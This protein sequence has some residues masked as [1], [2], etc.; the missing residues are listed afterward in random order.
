MP[1]FEDWLRN[2]QQIINN[3]FSKLSNLELKFHG[4]IFFTFALKT[5]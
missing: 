5:K 2:P 1:V 4:E 3:I